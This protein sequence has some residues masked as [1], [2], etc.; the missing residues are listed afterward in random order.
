MTEELN[1]I[2]GKFK[3]VKKMNKISYLVLLVL[4]LSIIGG[5]FFIKGQQSQSV[6]SYVMQSQIPNGVSQ[7]GGSIVGSKGNA[8]YYYWFVAKFPG[9]NGTPFGPIIIRNAPDILTTQNYIS[10]SWNPVQYATGYDIIRQS[11]NILPASC[12]SCAYTNVTNSTKNDQGMGLSNYSLVTITPLN[13]LFGVDSTQ[14]VFSSYFILANKIYTYKLDSN[15]KIDW[16]TVSSSTPYPIGAS[17]P[18][19]CDIGNIYFLVTATAGSNLNLCTSSNT[20]TQ[21]TGGGGGS[22]TPG[23]GILIPSGCTIAVDP[24]YT[25]I[26]EDLQSGKWIGLNAT[27]TNN[28]VGCPTNAGVALPAYYG[29]VVI[30]FANNS[31]ANSDFN[32]CSQG[33]KNLYRN[34]G[35]TRIGSGDIIAASG[36]YVFSYNPNLNG[37]AGGWQLMSGSSGSSSTFPDYT[38]VRILQNFC[39]GGGDNST[40]FNGPLGPFNWFALQT[41]GTGSLSRTFDANWPC[42]LTIT[43]PAAIDTGVVLTVNSNSGS[44]TG[45][46]KLNPATDTNWHMWFLFKIGDTTGMGYGLGI[47]TYNAGITNSCS[48]GSQQHCIAVAAGNGD[49]NWQARICNGFA[50]CT[51]SDLGVALSTVT[52]NT[53]EIWS[54]VAGSINFKINGGATITIS[55][56]TYVES[57]TYLPIVWS[58]SRDGT[59][60]SLSMREFDFEKTNLVN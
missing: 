26:G 29:L 30:K 36:L 35:T 8:T 47:T 33:V 57:A 58:I 17:L 53:A 18:N 55:N 15:A 6:S 22:C 11:Q 32:Y 40:S 16:S 44:G 1:I 34:D 14:N 31:T 51:N 59:A 42:I 24:N 20:W 48:N 43:S 21:I 54:T 10:L 49:T 39:G 56:P 52:I 25:V 5:K 19:S 12:N 46:P 28:Y 2:T 60:R 41:G 7:A 23:A 4:L 13:L 9:G 37:A 38:K 50:T 45:T 27:G 3:V